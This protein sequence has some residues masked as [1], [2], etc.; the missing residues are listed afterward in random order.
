M[1]ETRRVVVGWTL[2]GFVVLLRRF[3]LG[4]ALLGMTAC[5]TGND[6]KDVACAASLLFVEA[7]E[8]VGSTAGIEQGAVGRSAVGGAVDP[9]AR[10]Y[11]LGASVDPAAHGLV[12]LDGQL[13]DF[14]RLDSLQAQGCEPTQ[15]LEAFDSVDETSRVQI[16]DALIAVGQVELAVAWYEKADSPEAY[17]R[18]LKLHGSAGPLADDAQYL[19]Y[20]VQRAQLQQAFGQ[21][22]DWPAVGHAQ[23]LFVQSGRS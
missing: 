5:A 7:V 23:P 14:N 12:Q 8:G 16:A 17:E 3:G 15:M 20:E 18:L 22:V 1:G 21:Q 4:L 10:G 2:P 6:H 19:R 13:L 9:R 11:D